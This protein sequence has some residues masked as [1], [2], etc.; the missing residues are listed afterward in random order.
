[1]ETKLARIAKIAQEKAK[2]VFT[3]LY[4]L[5]YTEE[6]LDKCHEEVTPGKAAGVDDVTKEEYEENFQE[7][8]SDLSS[9]LARMGYRPQAVRRTHIPKGDGRTRPLGIPAHEDKVVQLGM[10]KILEAIFEQ[11]FL[12]CSYG[13]RP[14]KSCHDALKE[15]N[16][17]IEREKISYVVDADIR[18]ITSL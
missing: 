16:R 13:F 2:E 11:D 15:L 7:N 18:F 5:L 9:R 1:M 8:L 10:K 3:S 14:G 12:P 6:M 4:H 17:V